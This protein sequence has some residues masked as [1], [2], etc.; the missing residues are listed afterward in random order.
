MQELSVNKVTPLSRQ[1]QIELF[2]ASRT[3]QMDL[4]YKLLELMVIEER[5]NA[6]RVDPANEP[7]QRAA[8]TTAYAMNQL[9]QKFR[10]RVE[11]ALTEHKDE[12]A[13]K[14][15]EENARE[16]QEVEGVITYNQPR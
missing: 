14:A 15:A 6:A 9:Y 7:S 5:D 16:Q 4:V 8:W 13:K 2:A 3:R 1:E 10:T 11:E 12:I